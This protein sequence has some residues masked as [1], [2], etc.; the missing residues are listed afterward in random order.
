[1]FKLIMCTQSLPIGC[2]CVLINHKSLIISL[3]RIHFK[4]FNISRQGLVLII[5]L[6]LAQPRRA[7]ATPNSR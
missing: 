6:A 5:S 7:W 3:K 4:S 1:M 2:N